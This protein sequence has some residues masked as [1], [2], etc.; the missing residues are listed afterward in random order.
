MNWMIQ[1]MRNLRG[2]LNRILL[3]SHQKESAD[4]F[5][6]YCF[7]LLLNSKKWK[8]PLTNEEEKCSSFR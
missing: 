7:E 1:E 4:A 2:R 8:A 3:V 5:D 6:G